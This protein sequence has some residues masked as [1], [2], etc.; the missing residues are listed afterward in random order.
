MKGKNTNVPKKCVIIIAQWYHI[1]GQVILKASDIVV[2]STHINRYSNSS[3]R[4]SMGN[5]NKFG[6]ICVKIWC[7]QTLAHCPTKDQTF[8]Q[9]WSWTS[10]SFENP[11]QDLKPHCHH[12]PIRNS[13]C[14]SIQKLCKMFRVMLCSLHPDKGKRPILRNS[15]NLQIN[16]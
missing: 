9:S 11:L 8:R 5:S 3:R 14:K 12:H 10:P 2:R 6:F 4:R 7:S 16:Q 15:K 13:N 1:D